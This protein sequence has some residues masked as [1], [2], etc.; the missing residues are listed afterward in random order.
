MNNNKR[1]DMVAGRLVF[2]S[3][4]VTPAITIEMA[5]KPNFIRR[6]CMW[7]FLGV[8]WQNWWEYHKQ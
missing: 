4:F 5:Y 3:G 2:N 7:A 6:W 8:T 1:N